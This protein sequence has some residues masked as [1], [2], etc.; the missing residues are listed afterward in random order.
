MRE[1]VLEESLV[2]YLSGSIIGNSGYTI[3]ISRGI[4]KER[5]GGGKIGEENIDKSK[6][7]Y[8]EQSQPGEEPR[9]GTGF[10]Y[11]V[12]NKLPGGYCYQKNDDIDNYVF[13]AR[14]TGITV[15]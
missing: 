9:Q 11:F 4:K 15:K 2:V 1:Y 10:K 12:A 3:A 14:G 5:N 13:I 7:D 8:R 6:D